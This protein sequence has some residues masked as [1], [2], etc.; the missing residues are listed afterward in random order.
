[1]EVALAIDV[2]D[3]VRSLPTGTCSPLVDDVIFIFGTCCCEDDVV[4]LFPAA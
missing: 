1:L 3:T 4:V 2:P